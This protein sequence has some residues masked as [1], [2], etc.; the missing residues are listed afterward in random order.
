MADESLS[1]VK[2]R[3]VLMITMPADPDDATV[4]ALQD[5]VL[6]V[7]EQSDATGVILD[8]SAVETLDSFFAR[9]VAETAQMVALMGG[10]TIIAGM[11]PSVAIT[12]TQLGL[13]LGGATTALDVDRALAILG[14][15][16]QRGRVR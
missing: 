9:T 1:I 15:T 4:A 16:H 13:T 12:T 11:R 2:V 8:I 5:K 10:R 3:D 6:V 14:D 7:I